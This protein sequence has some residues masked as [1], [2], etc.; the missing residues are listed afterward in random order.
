[1]RLRPV[2]ALAASAAVALVLAGCGHDV[3]GTTPTGHPTSSCSPPAG[4][5]CAADVAWPGPISVAQGGRV[6][7][8]IIN[9]G[10]TLAVL[11]QT[12]DRV[13][14]R[15]HVDAMGAGSMSCARVD[16]SAHLAAPLAGRPVYDEVTGHQIRVVGA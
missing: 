10:G 9:C 14:V 6:L 2:F 4:G 7:H 12:A 13:T 15:L 16:V 5:R 11:Q 3:A 1:M 8:G